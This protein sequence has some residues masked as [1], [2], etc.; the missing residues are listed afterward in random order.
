[1][2]VTAFLPWARAVR[3]SPGRAAAPAAPAARPAAMRPK[4]RREILRVS[5]MA[6]LLGWS[7][8][9][10][11][12]GLSGSTVDDGILGPWHRPPFDQPDQAEQ[13]ERHRSEVNTSE[14]QSQ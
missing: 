6:V 13:G 10:W 2:K 4:L 5:V 3:D 7:G 11:V 8:W 14:L 9:G 12:S 1:M